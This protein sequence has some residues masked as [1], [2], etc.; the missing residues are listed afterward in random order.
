M[1]S[2]TKD[3]VIEL[4][5]ARDL[6]QAESARIIGRQRRQ[7]QNYENGTSQMPAGLWLL[8][9]IQMGDL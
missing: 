2:P 4:R 7:W 1:Q 9:R 5:K 8:Y 6:T 3:Q